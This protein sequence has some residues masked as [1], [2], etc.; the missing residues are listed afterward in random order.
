M[1]SFVDGFLA[2]TAAPCT[3]PTLPVAAGTRIP[4][5]PR[6]QA[7]AAV[8]WGEV[9]NGWHARVE[10]VYV[11][12]VPVNNFGDEA[13]PSYAVFN[14]SVGYGFDRRPCVRCTRQPW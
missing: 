3:V 9:S 10:G 12:A 7:Q 4:G 14:A 6:T 11:D 1:R 8:R 13:A 2:C 5:I